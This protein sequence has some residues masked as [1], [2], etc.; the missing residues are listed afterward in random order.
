MNP[1]RTIAVTSG[2]GGV[3][4][5][6][7]AANLAV[8]FRRL[9]ERV[10]LFDA[11][12]GLSNVDVLL[13]LMTPYNIS[14]VLNGNKHLS[15]IIVEGPQGIKVLPASSGIQELTQLNEFQRLKLL[16]EFDAF[17]GEIDTLIIDTGAGISSNVAFFC[18]SAQTILIVVS[19]EPTSLT[20][21]YA[22]I[23]VLHTRYQ[24]KE[25]KILVN[26]VRDAAEGLRVFK[27]LAVAADKYLHVSL[28]YLGYLVFDEAVPK[29]VM[30]Q[31]SF[32]DCFPRAE[33]SR[34]LVAVAEKLKEG[35]VPD[36]R[37]SLQL[38]I[39]N[40]IG[41]ERNVRH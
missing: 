17:T 32:V 33:V 2:K 10:L 41:E 15:E 36:I 20:D 23:K 9:G 24:E 16:E 40:L 35:I 11:D 7:V 29:A 31:K 18:I 34:N 21:S 12:L 22:L 27:R 30:A 14:H 1:I 19:P 28:D 26:S 38:F 37:G 6:N 4:K 25:F 13:G 3:G 8:A 39:G 5:T